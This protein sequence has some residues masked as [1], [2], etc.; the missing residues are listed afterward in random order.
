M[1]N[2]AKKEDNTQLKTIKIRDITTFNVRGTDWIMTVEPDVEIDD[3]LRPEYWTHVAG[4]TFRGELNYIHVLWKDKSRLAKLYVIDY[5]NL[6]AS[7]KV[8]EYFDFRKPEAE[9]A[10][11]E[12][13]IKE[14][15]KPA[16]RFTVKWS[17]PNTKFKIIRVSDDAVMADNIK[18]KEEAEAQVEVF[19]KDHK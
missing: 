12:S 17:G 19:E 14:I 16:A 4:S 11:E 6:Y 1:T 7:V 2:T 3:M 5:N 8:V 9:T 13:K 15:E 18:T 10:K